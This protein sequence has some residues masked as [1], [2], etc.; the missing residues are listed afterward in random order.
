M[1]RRNVVQWLEGAGLTLLLGVAA[2]AAPPK[3]GT[4]ARPAASPAKP[5][6]PGPPREAEAIAAIEKL[7][8]HVQ[9]IAQSDDRLEVSFRFLGT[10]VTDA[11]LAAL[12][13]LKKLAH[14]DLAHTAVGDAGLVHLKDLTGLTRLHLENTK[15]T[16]RGLV[17][18][19]NL[20]EL[21]YLNLYGTAVTDAG[22]EHLRGLT[23]LKSLYLWQ[24]KVTE[25][26]VARLK[27]ALP[28]ATIVTGAE[29]APATK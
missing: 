9:P 10:N 1:Q 29:A 13:P 18:L 6:P 21:E 11:A 27:Q 22:L 23:K 5:T 25:A 24:T 4:S 20:K 16:D 8:G 15:V 14:L 7:G 12:R 3:R 2:H 28:Q 26:G 17:H 19:K